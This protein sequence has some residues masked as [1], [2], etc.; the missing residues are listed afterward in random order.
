[1]SDRI[2]FI[3]HR[4]SHVLHVKMFEMSTFIF[5]INKMAFTMSKRTF[6]LMPS[7]QELG[8]PGPLKK[9]VSPKVPGLVNCNAHIYA[10]KFPS[11]NQ[12]V[13]SMRRSIAEA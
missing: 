12:E 13:V 8:H 4:I 3:Y 11:S 5:Y 2:P 1:M 10:S 7:H 6:V 9:C